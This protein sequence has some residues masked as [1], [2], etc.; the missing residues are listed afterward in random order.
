M[1][2]FNERMRIDKHTVTYTSWS[3]KTDFFLTGITYYVYFK[4]CM[5]CL[6]KYASFI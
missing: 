5:T 2:S 4:T 1:K 6:D 3:S